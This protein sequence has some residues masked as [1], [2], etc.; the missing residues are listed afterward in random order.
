MENIMETYKT[1]ISK[2]SLTAIALF[3]AAGCA[4]VT[5]AN[6]DLMD[7]PT[8]ETTTMER[9]GDTWDQKTGDDMDVIIVKPVMTDGEW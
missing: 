6:T 2:L 1:L 4:T 5:D 3:F 7:E 9:A 8:E